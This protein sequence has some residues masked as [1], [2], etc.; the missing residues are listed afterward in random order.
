MIFGARICL[1]RERKPHEHSKVTFVELFFDL[2]FVFAITQLSR[3]LLE[4]FTVAGV[5]ETA[6]M[7]AAVWWVWIYTSWATNWLDPQT[8]P[9]RVVLFVLMLAGLVLS[10]S[11]PEAFGTRAASFAGAYVLMQAGRCVFML[12]ALRRHDGGNYRNFQRITSWFAL[13]ALFWIAGMFA[14]GQMRFAL[15]ALAL[16]IEYAAP[17]AGFWTPGLGRS[18]SVEWDIS[19]AHIAERC[20]L[21]IIIALGESILVTGATFGK[22]DW[23]AATAAAFAIA[24]IGSVAMW[25]IYFNIGAERATEY[26]AAS[27]DPGRHARVAYTYTHLL[28]VAGIIVTAVSDELVLAHPGGHVDFKTAVTTVGGPALFLVG[29]LIFKRMLAGSRG[30][31]HMV[32]L[33]LLVLAAPAALI[34]PPLALGAIASAILVIVAI[35]ETRSLGG[36]APSLPVAVPVKP[37]ARPKKRKRG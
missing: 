20:G 14:G 16:A 8:T 4:H 25:W 31:S 36:T 29:N 32:G 21:F 23:M 22:M 9:V 3:Y 6:L 17:A 30:L 37:K 11:I 5:L 19:G 34:V 15:W 24:F 7:L 12:W 2:I 13:S 33:G 27:D 26:I 10:T 1:L 28:P 18:R 35:W